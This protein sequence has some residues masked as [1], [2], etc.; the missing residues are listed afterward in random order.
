MFDR[1]SPYSGFR[2]AASLNSSN[3]P[4][5]SPCPIS[6]NPRVMQSLGRSSVYLC[7]VF[8]LAIL[9]RPALGAAPAYWQDS[10][11][12]DDQHWL[13]QA[14]EA[15]TARD[16]DRA[17]QCYTR[18]LKEHPERADVLQRLGLAYYLSN[19]FSDAIPRLERALELNPSLW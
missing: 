10:N 15:E 9:A 7:L 17:A 11:P 16:F 6:A 4:L 8:M 5:R 19:R 12:A 2:R 18:F 13:A 14:K 1:A 3:A